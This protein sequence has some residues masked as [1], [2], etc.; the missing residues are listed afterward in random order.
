M[1]F[2]EREQENMDT[3]DQRCDAH[4]T[5]RLENEGH[6]GRLFVGRTRKDTKTRPA[7]FHLHEIIIVKVILV[8]CGRFELGAISLQRCLRLGRLGLLGALVRRTLLAHLLV[9]ERRQNARHLLDLSAVQVLDQLFAKFGYPERV[10]R[11]LRVGRQ[12]RDQR[13]GQRR[14]LLL[15]SGL[16]QRHRREIN[17]L[18]WIRGV[19]DHDG[20]GCPPIPVQIKVPKEIFGVLEVRLLLRP[21]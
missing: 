19:P 12:Q 4:K 5:K 16:E 7:D 2:Y 8:V 13:V 14:E 20:L 21:T 15:V 11:L 18:G 1:E 6:N 17:R 10:L 9:A 3:E